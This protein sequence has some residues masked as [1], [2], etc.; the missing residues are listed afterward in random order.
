MSKG[1]KGKKDELILEQLQS[2]ADFIHDNEEYE[3]KVRDMRLYMSPVV[4]GE[5]VKEVGYPI[6]IV[7]GVRIEVTDEE[8]DY[9]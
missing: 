6:D 8:L 9:E 4:Y 2:L 5:L 3:D 1:K 7:G